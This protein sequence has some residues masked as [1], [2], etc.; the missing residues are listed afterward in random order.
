MKVLV[1]KQSEL[2]SAGRCD[3][4]FH[5]PPEHLAQFPDDIIVRV[6]KVANVVK[7]KRNP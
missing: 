1:K 2:I 5:L 6:D 3:I 4:D 7:E